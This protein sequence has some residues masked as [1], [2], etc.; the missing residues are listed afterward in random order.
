MPVQDDARENQMVQLFN[1]TVPDNR[2]RGDIDAY[3]QIDGR[4]V[5]FELKSTTSGSV[6][7][8]RD[9]GPD[10]IAKWRAGLHWLFAFYDHSGTKLHHCVYASPKDMESWIAEKERYIRP[11]IMLADTVPALIT[12]D[13]VATILGLK[14]V[15]DEVDAK[16][17]MKNQ[18]T[19][20]DFRQ[21]QDMP[22]GYSLGRM[23][24]ILQIRARY[25]MMRG[26][27]LNNPHIESKFFES[28]DQITEEH[29]SQLRGL[30]RTYFA[31][32]DAAE[33]ATA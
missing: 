16:W 31:K 1:L 19:A 8:V 9:F 29:A 25:V 30:V 33:Q 2:G 4:T 14:E 11:D 23:T 17:I 7:T 20:A 12:S 3:L 18:W 26:A 13:A 15:Y 24:S 32:A 5:P 22:G 10:H 27:T 28:F 6:S 21:H